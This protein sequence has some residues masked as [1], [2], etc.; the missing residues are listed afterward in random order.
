MLKKPA[1]I[2]ANLMATKMVAAKGGAMARPQ[3]MMARAP[4]ATFQREPAAISKSSMIGAQIGKRVILQDTAD[5]PVV[6]VQSDIRAAQ[7]V[8]LDQQAVATREIVDGASTQEVNSKS[9]SLTFDYRMVYAERKW[10]SGGFLFNNRWYVPGCAAGEFASGTGT[11]NGK[12]EVIPMAALLVK[13]LRISADWSHDDMVNAASAAAFGPFSLF[14]S[15]TEAQTNTIVCQGM[16][17]VA[18]VCEPLPMLPPASDP[19]K[20]AAA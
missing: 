1:L 6:T 8:R 13:N 5:A 16:Q 7:L 10:V 4:A 12:C 15:N 17:I 20:A 9:V 2:S 14:E 11:G 19:A 3:M 18:W